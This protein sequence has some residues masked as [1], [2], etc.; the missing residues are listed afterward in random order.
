[1]KR[2]FGRFMSLLL[3]LAMVLAMVPAALAANAYSVEPDST[4]TLT[5]TYTFTEATWTSS[6]S[7][8]AKIESSTA[9]TAVI[10]GVKAS[11]TAIRI[12]ATGKVNGRD[13]S[14]YFTVYVRDAYTLT[15]ALS[16]SN[17]NGT[18]ALNQG[19]TRTLTATVTVGSSGVTAG[20]LANCEVHF[21]SDND[22]ISVT[23]AS[24]KV[25]ASTVGH[26]TTYKV[27]ATVKAEKVGGA[28]LT[29]QV[30]Y[31]GKD[32]MK[33]STSATATK[34]IGFRVSGAAT[35]SVTLPTAQQVLSLEAGGTSA[36]LQPKVTGY[37]GTAQPKLLYLYDTKDNNLYVRPNAS[38]TSATVEPY[39]A[40]DATNIYI[41]IES[42]N[43]GKTYNDVKDDPEHSITGSY[44]VC[45]VS[46]KNKGMAV[47]ALEVR[48]DQSV[49]VTDID[50]K[51]TTTRLQTQL[52]SGAMVFGLQDSN[53]NHDKNG[54]NIK[55]SNLIFTEL[56]LTARIKAPDT[57]L[58]SETDRKNAYSRIEWTS[59]APTVA[60]VSETNSDKDSATAKI[61]AVAPG[62]ATITAKVD[63][64]VTATYNVTVYQ[65]RAYKITEEPSIGE[66]VGKMTDTELKAM[67]EK[68]SAKVEIQTSIYADEVMIYELPVKT[69][70]VV[71]GTN[72]GKKFKY[73]LNGLKTATKEF[74]YNREDPNGTGVTTDRQVTF[75]DISFSEQPA[76]AAYKI[77]DTIADLAM[78]ASVSTGKIKS[79]VWYMNSD[80]TTGG[81]DK[82]I[83][84]DKI[85]DKPTNY[86]SVLSNLK[87]YIT[88]TGTYVFY[89]RVTT[90]DGKY[91][92]TRK[93]IITITGE[94]HINIVFNPTTVKAGGTFTITG[95]PQEYVSGKLTNVTGKTYTITWTS[96]DENIVKLSSKTSTNSSP[97]IT[98]TA[99]AGGQVTIKAETTIGA[100]KYAAEVKFTVTV[101]EADTVSLTLGEN[102]TYVQLDG[103]KLA[104]AV[105][106]A[107]KVTP[108][109][110]T[111]ESPANGTLYTSSAMSG[112]VSTTT[113]YSA[114]EVSKM[115]YRPTRTTGT[116]T[117][118]YAAYDGS[119]QIATG[120]I[121]VVTS[122]ST[123]EYHISANE[124]QQ[125]VVSDF[126]RVYGSGLSTVTFGSNTDTRGALYK[127]STTS[128]GK[129]GSEAYSV[130]TGSN[131]LKNVCFIAGSTTS[132]YTVTIPF[133]ANGSSGQ[134]N[135][136]LVVYVNDTHT[137]NST[138][139][140][141]RS[142]GIAGELTPENATGSTYITI[143]RVVG[144]KLY[145]AYTSIKNCT[146]LTSKDF[147][148]TKFYF[149]GSGSLDN[150]YILPLADSKS[151]EVSYTIDG[152][153][154]GTLSFKVNQQ[155]ASNQFTDV[156]GSYK[157][158]ANSVDFMYMN[159]II[160]G[161]N[162]KNPK[163]FGPGAKMTR[164][165]LVTVLYRAA[166]EPTVTGITNKFTD[167]KQGQYYYNAVLWASNMGIVNGATATTFDP[168]GNV[169]REQIAAILYRYEGSPTVT[170][171]LSGYPDQAQVSSF[172]VTA[173]Q[174]AVGTGI[175]TGVTSGGRTTL[176]A[177]GN[178]TRAQVAVMLHRFLTF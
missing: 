159:D 61:K 178:A 38:T 69:A 149:S 136:Q 3:V 63:G 23:P 141:F 40:C 25:T 17:I 115:V 85:T 41:C 87:Q 127:G 166:G 112:T 168:N 57:L 71:N 6:D 100:K 62:T 77:T 39:K 36:T 167:N 140:S 135:G 170:G 37:S 165:M 21:T 92:E 175:I 31:Q 30:W 163:L 60:K 24:A 14:E 56:T 105:K 45:T 32:G 9:T 65:G 114:S 8:V 26:Y 88:G 123:V 119:A 48:N 107:A 49:T 111:F 72:G 50:G 122:A 148:S 70:E 126:Q 12:T 176:S 1:M 52:D 74:F 51:T 80:Q 95:T 133:T 132:K 147:G 121:N 90:D 151:V 29:A 154:K 138:G 5:T 118:R 142:M 174:W 68:E 145:S 53:Y 67:F 144:G 103:S 137:L 43:I 150:L 4:I 104:A 113:K 171:S 64:N 19:D 99:K 120:T 155:T 22:A 44:A 98:A 18:V 78:T 124:K 143:D 42:Y 73:T 13:Y 157:W 131:L 33:P 86:R 152:S 173:M 116:H 81:V 83:Q 153:T 54:T 79:V 164:A 94:N 27:E 10:K 66:T 128:S 177:K 2:T 35:I 108:S 15:L 28:T 97:S 134:M 16:N 75:S 129:V 58:N 130:S 76:N 59:S 11:T 158:A 169:T 102:E 89:C 110:F 93:A 106:T 7:T 109:T 162:T 96:S 156:S 46:I 146:A 47:T 34:T 91:A 82:A 161:N 160:K 55:N 20:N 125:M 84:T 117:I 172:A 139:A 101:P